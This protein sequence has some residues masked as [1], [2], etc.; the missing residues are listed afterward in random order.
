MV[1]KLNITIKGVEEEVYKHF[2]AESIRR[3]F[4]LGEATTEALRDWVASRNRRSVSD[5]KSMKEAVRHM[6]E[7]KSKLKNWS[8]VKEIRK[9]REKRNYLK[10]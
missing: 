5:V 1:I 2:K 9:W 3:G 4:K 7:I 10:S 8:G 6:D